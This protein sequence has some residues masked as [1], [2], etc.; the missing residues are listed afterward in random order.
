MI[1]EFQ[2]LAD[3]QVNELSLKKDDFV[4]GYIIGD[5]FHGFFL[6]GERVPDF[7]IPGSEVDLSYRLKRQQEYPSL[8]DLADALYWK[9]KGDNGLF[10]DYI[11]KCEQVK[12]KYPKKGNVLLG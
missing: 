12:I 9:E 3:V 6:N 8:A 10:D 11:A 1:R 7:Q 5:L 4:D 2:I